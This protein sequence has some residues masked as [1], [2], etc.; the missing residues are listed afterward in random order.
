MGVMDARIH[1]ASELLSTGGLKNRNVI[2]Q[3][4]KKGV[5]V[6]YEWTELGLRM[7]VA[8]HAATTDRANEIRT[9]IASVPPDVVPPSELLHLPDDVVPQPDAIDM[10][11]ASELD[12]SNDAQTEN[13]ENGTNDAVNPSGGSGEF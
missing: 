2:R 13:H 7:L 3:G 11:E 12:M 8:L 9:Q 5:A 10:R 6:V 1:A 4:P